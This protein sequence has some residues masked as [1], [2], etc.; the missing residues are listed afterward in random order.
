MSFDLNLTTLCD[1]TVYRELA[2]LDYDLRSLRLSK[3]L[4]SSRITLY[5]TDNLIP[6]SMYQIVEDE[7]SGLP[8]SDPVLNK[9]ILFN[10]LWR[11]F[12]DYFEVTYLTTVNYCTKCLGSK[13]LDDIS[14]DVKGGL[15][16]TRDERLL[17][18]NV[19]KFVITRINSNSFH[20]FIGTSIEGLIGSRL[21][22]VQFLITQLKA[23][24]T[25]TLQKFQDLQAQYR[26]SGRNLT[27][28]EVLQS[29]D[30]VSVNQDVIDPTVFRISITVVAESGQTVTFD[31]IIRLRG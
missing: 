17:M 5:A 13:Y 27:S 21:N 31:Q 6:D 2:I 29:I 20:T 4:A 18:Q 10:H 11:S 15:Y 30:N 19:E 24:V 12:T 26:E 1:H 23:E 16:T 7:R 8:E 25:R 9:K 14:Y 3:P 28:G 22:N